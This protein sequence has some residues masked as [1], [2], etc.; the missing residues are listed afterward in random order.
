[1][2]VVVTDAAFAVRLRCWKSMLSMP[3]S[4]LICRLKLCCS[5]M[6]SSFK[7]GLGGVG[8][9]GAA[10]VRLWGCERQICL[11][12]DADVVLRGSGKL[13][14][15]VVRIMMGACLSG[16]LRVGSFKEWQLQC[17]HAH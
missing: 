2:A 4:D 10:V 5:S 13:A 1:M 8:G 17:R 16:K 11:L 3:A 14:S 12:D 7:V 9:A 15:T 6:H